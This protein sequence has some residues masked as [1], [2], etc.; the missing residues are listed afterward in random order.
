LD[1]VLSFVPTF[2]SLLKLQAT[3]SKCA[4]R[5]SFLR[6]G[7]L[8]CKIKEL[9]G[10]LVVHVGRGHGANNPCA[11]HV[12]NPKTFGDLAVFQFVAIFEG[13]QVSA[14]ACPE[15]RIAYRTNKN[16]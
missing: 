10:A 14:S 6:V 1:V 5:L 11:L 2:F 15:S 3:K 12:L 13:R 7:R 4:E 16:V 9:D 8:T